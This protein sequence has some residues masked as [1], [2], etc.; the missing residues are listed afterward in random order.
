MNDKS[1][2]IYMHFFHSPAEEKRHWIIQDCS[3]QGHT[4]WIR[5]YALQ[6]CARQKKT[7]LKYWNDNAT[8][9]ATLCFQ[10][11]LA[12][13]SNGMTVA[14]QRIKSISQSLC[15]TWRWSKR[16]TLIWKCSLMR[17]N[18]CRENRSHGRLCFV[19]IVNTSTALWS[20]AHTWCFAFCG[21]AS[22]WTLHMPT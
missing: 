7:T 15:K 2:I 10:L 16:W 4:C 5:H 14:H 19:E 12:Y 17:F 11:S 1:S 13:I 20:Q 22:I 9:A 18:R 3:N 21:Q 8:P 6:F